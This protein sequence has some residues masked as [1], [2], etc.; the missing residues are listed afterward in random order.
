MTSNSWVIISFVR[1]SDLEGQHRHTVYDGDLPHPFALTVFEDTVYWTDWNTRTVEKGNKYDGSGRVALVNTTHRPFD[2]HVYHPY[3]QP[4]GESNSRGQELFVHKIVFS[5]LN[6]STRGRFKDRK[7]PQAEQ[8]LSCICPAAVSWD[9][10]TDL[11]LFSLTGINPCAVNNGGCSHLCL[12]RHGG[13]EHTCECP[14]HF[15]TVQIGGVTRCLPMCTSTQYRC[16]NNER[17]VKIL[18]L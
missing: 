2:I 10:L 13:R 18:F 16:A 14:D 8:Y 17:F 7:W 15:L 9:C 11:R 5:Y 6:M 3:R 4:I 12:I 1:Y